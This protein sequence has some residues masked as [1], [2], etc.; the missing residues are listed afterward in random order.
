MFKIVYNELVM[1][2][3]DTVG[4]SGFIINMIVKHHNFSKSMVIDR[5]S[6]FISKFRY[7]LCYLL[8][9]KQKLSI[10]IYPQT[11]GQTER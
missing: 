10:V 11:N 5:D 1:T 2:T 4:P 3:I 7:L 6:L 9:I 8:G